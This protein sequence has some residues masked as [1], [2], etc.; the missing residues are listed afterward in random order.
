MSRKTIKKKTKTK[1]CS[2]RGRTLKQVQT[3]IQLPPSFDLYDLNYEK[4]THSDLAVGLVY[5]NSSKSKRLLMN[6]LYVAEKLKVAEIPF[7]TLEMYTDTPELHDAFHL[8]TSFILF[9]KERLCHLLEQKIPAHFKKLLFMDSDL[10]FQ[11]KNWYNEL[12]EKLNHF[13][14]VQPFEKGVWLDITYK[15]VVKER[16]PFIFYKKFG[17]IATEGGI[18]GYHPG[19]AWAFQRDWFRQVGFFQYGVLGDGDTLSST[20]WLQYPDFQYSPFI[21]PAID[22]FR[23]LLTRVPTLCFLDGYIFH[24]WHGD[25]SKRQYSSRRKIFERVKDVRDIIREAPNG[26]FELKDDSLKPKIRAYFKN[27]DDDGLAITP[28]V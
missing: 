3:P 7:Y 21:Q 22:E 1:I 17:R 28:G 13:E 14:I 5:F 25:G 8:K 4:P 23:K 27:R 11:K 6:Y 20:V 10:I 2:F 19:F 16:I 9:Q 18:G 26:L 24:L 12:S 15:H